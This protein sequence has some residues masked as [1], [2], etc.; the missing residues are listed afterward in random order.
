MSPPIPYFDLIREMKDAH[1]HRLRLVD[2]ARH[3]GIKAAARAFQ[4]TVA[5]VRDF[6]D[7]VSNSSRGKNFRPLIGMQ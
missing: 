1:N 5:T 2:Y 6:G 4:T 3:H 7:G